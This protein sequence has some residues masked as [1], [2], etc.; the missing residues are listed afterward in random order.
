MFRVVAPSACKCLAGTYRGAKACKAAYRYAVMVGSDPLVGVDPAK[1]AINMSSFE[2]QCRLIEDKFNVWRSSDVKPTDE[3]VLL[4]LVEVLAKV[5][6]RFFQIHPYA[7]GNGH[8]GR[9]LILV[10]MTRAGFSPMKWSIDG[11]QDYADEIYRYR[12]GD[13]QPLED[14][15]LDAI[16]GS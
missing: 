8:A 13:K 16:G 4:E 2:A 5:L 11:K 10:L 7:N 1:V 3:L 14:F 9:F 6:E 12:R 15:L